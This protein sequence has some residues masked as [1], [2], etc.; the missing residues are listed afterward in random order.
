[1]LRLRSSLVSVWLLAL[2]WMAASAA[3]AQGSNWQLIN[4]P[5]TGPG[6]STHG[7]APPPASEPDHLY[8]LDG[9]AGVHASPLPE[10]FKEDL[11]PLAQQSGGGAVSFGLEE[12]ETVYIV[13]QEIVEG[14]LAS[15]AAGVLTPEIEAIAEPLDEETSS[16][17]VV[18]NG[19]FGECATH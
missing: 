6:V 12:D 14:I 9:A 11:A 17:A 18:A 10:S 3:L 1:M 2:F 13:G 15:E 4:A 7:T 8:L 5:S 16:S 19:L